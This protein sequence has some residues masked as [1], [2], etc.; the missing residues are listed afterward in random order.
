MNYLHILHNYFLNKQMNH[1]HI[2]YTYFLNKQMNYLHILHNYFLYKNNMMIC[3]YLFL[4]LNSNGND[5]E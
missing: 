1:L 4:K 5:S 2:Q 3:G